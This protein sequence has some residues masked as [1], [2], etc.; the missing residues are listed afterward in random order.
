MCPQVF[1]LL[2]GKT[3]QHPWHPL[4]PETL[5]SHGERDMWELVKFWNEKEIW[6]K[7]VTS[8]GLQVIVFLKTRVL[9]CFPFLLAAPFGSFP[10]P[11]FPT[12]ARWRVLE[13]RTRL[14]LV[15]MTQM[16]SRTVTT[17]PSLSFNNLNLSFKLFKFT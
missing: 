14:P 5:T 8:F 3:E 9:F 6:G 2:G 16:N 11:T 17:K 15:K 4:L 12:K 13:P 10:S 7:H 1:V